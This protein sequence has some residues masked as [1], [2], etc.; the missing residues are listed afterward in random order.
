MRDECDFC[1]NCSVLMDY[2][3]T[4]CQLCRAEVLICNS[5]KDIRISDIPQNGAH[6][7]DFHRSVDLV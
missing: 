4:S 6:F 1:A 7:K 3:R 5:C 2:M